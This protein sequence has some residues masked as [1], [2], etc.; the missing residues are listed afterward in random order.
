MG[1]GTAVIISGDARSNYRDGGVDP[2]QRIAER[3]RRV[4]WL[5]P[6]PCELWGTTDSLIDTFRHGCTAVHE[7]R[8]LGQL[9]DVIAE[10]IGAQAVGTDNDGR[11]L[12]IAGSKPAVRL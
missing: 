3:A 7:V 1:S 8:T 2:F 12:S 4:Y 10:L 11:S 5:N 9:A 6:E